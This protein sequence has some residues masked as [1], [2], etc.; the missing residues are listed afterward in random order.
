MPTNGIGRG[1]P[2]LAPVVVSMMTGRPASSPGPDS[3]PLLIRNS[4]RSIAYN[5]FWNTHDPGPLAASRWVTRCAA[6][7][8]F[9][10]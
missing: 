8:G 4:G 2:L 10:A 5:V 9:T 7:A 1:R 3:R 6:F